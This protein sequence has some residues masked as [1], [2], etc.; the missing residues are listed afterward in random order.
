MGFIIDQ[1]LEQAN[2]ARRSARFFGRATPQ[3][4]SSAIR[5]ALSPPRTQGTA[6]Q[7]KAL[8]DAYANESKYEDALKWYME[9][10]A[11][12][13]S[14][15]AV[16]ARVSDRAP[17]RRRHGTSGTHRGADAARQRSRALVR[18]RI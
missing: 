11:D 6:D 5:A 17:S 15:G 18:P 8:G 9:S 1:L 10:A 3:G 14:E 12:G 13:S 4:P 16:A 2:G 7:K